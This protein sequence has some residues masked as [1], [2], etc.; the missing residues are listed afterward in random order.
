MN[1]V[2][3]IFEGGVFKP[4]EPVSL[5]EHCVVEFEPRLTSQA[6]T[7]ALQKVYEVLN[8]RYDSGESDVSERHNEH[9]P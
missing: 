9:Q 2:H 7:E 3:A 6:A 1:T 8:R 4:T 5:P